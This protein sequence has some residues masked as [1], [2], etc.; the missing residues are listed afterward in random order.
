MSVGMSA[1]PAVVAGIAVAL[2]V[3]LAGFETLVVG[4]LT[5]ESSV[6]VQIVGFGIAVTAAFAAPAAGAALGA[7]LVLRWRKNAL[8]RAE[9]ARDEASIAWAPATR[10]RGGI[11][12]GGTLVLQPDE[13]R[14]VRHRGQV[15]RWPRPVEARAAGKRLQV[16]DAVVVVADLDG[17]LREIAG[18]T[19]AS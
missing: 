19:R 1:L 11:A 15:V 18:R 5:A 12:D 10:M 13:V 3:P 4:T 8:R 6:A 16:A 2:A 14:F 7:L 9:E 17:W